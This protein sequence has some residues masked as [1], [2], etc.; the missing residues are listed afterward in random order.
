MAGTTRRESGLGD[1]QLALTK[2]FVHERG[3]VPN[4]LGSFS[5]KTTTGESDINR[6]GASLGSGFHAL[7][8]AVTAV[9]REDPLVYFGTLYY[10]TSLSDTRAG[11]KIDPGDAIGVRVG[12]IL[13]A[14]PQTSLRFDFDLSRISELQINGGGVAGTDQVVALFEMALAKVISPRI[15]L[16]VE[17]GLGVTDD[18]PDFR[19]G[20]SLPIRL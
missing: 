4:V 2:Q 13:A 9:K 10:T 1:V 11:N 8:G 18:A 15:L 16:D 7:Q 17:L 14:S 5:W 19:I 3:R 20:L 6:D 12:T